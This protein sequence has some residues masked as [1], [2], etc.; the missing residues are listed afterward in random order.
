MAALAVWRERR[1][2]IALVLTDMVMPEGLTGRELAEKLWAEAPD[3]P[4]ILTSGYR[5]HMA[6]QQRGRS[7]PPK[8]LLTRKAG[9][10]GA[11]RPGCR[12]KAPFPREPAAPGSAASGRGSLACAVVGRSRSREGHTRHALQEGL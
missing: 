1:S 12:G 9:H 2:E 4:V 10:H 3:L 11:R 8:T 5:A 6:G 7:L